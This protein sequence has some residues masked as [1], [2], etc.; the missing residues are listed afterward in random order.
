M[1]NRKNDNGKQKLVRKLL[2]GIVSVML[3][4]MI[5][6]CGS[7]GNN[8]RASDSKASNSVAS[9]ATSKQMQVES[10]EFS[11]SNADSAAM[12]NSAKGEIAMEPSSAPELAASSLGTTSVPD[13]S[14]YDRKLIYNA[15]VVLEVD[16]YGEA[17]TKLQNMVALA[18]G[19]ML[20]F[21][22]V[23]SQYES[24]GS[25][26][27]KIPSKGF[28]SFVTKLEELKKK[29]S[30]VERNIHGNDVTEE[31]VDIESRL[32]A[33]QVVE[34]RLLDFM[35]KATDTKNLLQFSN[36]LAIVQEEIEAIKGR[37]RFINQNVAFSTVDIRMYQQQQ[38]TVANQVEKEDHVLQRAGHAMKASGKAV[39]AILEGILIVLAGAL[40]VI[41]VFGAMIV[42]VWYIYRKTRY[43]GHRQNKSSYVTS[44][45]KEQP[46]VQPESSTHVTDKHE[47]PNTKQEE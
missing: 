16:N 22:D 45:S 17:Q 14:A 19:Y 36:Q 47:E 20:N 42:I 24:G 27:I 30:K 4:V 38:N 43:T 37:M 12:D 15:N 39:L 6:G 8:D 23:Q 41:I 25:F 28:H 40:P 13:F 9:P 32:K 10:V 44:V 2:I 3:I 11:R 46:S 34:A 18:G 1:I 35:N 21:N 5:S 7:S 33:K 26:V 31:Y 29:D